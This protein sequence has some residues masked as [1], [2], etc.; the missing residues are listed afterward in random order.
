MLQNTTQ[1]EKRINDMLDKIY[2][3][4]VNGIGSKKSIDGYRRT[5][6]LL[7]NIQYEMQDK[8]I[9]YYAHDNANLGVI[10][11]AVVKSYLK[12]NAQSSSSAG[13]IDLVQGNK[14]FEIKLVVKGSSSY[15]STLKETDMDVLI[16]SN[17]GAYILRK[18]NLQKAFEQGY[19]K[20]GE[21]KL[22]PTILHSDLIVETSFTKRL[23]D[24]LNLQA[25]Y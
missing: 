5:V 11:E 10:I 6:D 25:W 18:E 2:D 8:G 7:T 3:Y 13:Q 22:K 4:D 21:L 15:A 14:K 24:D 9:E 1:L 17:L 23:T 12:G 16:I 20:K 19:F